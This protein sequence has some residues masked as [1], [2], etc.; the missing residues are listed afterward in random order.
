MKKNIKLKCDDVSYM[1]TTT[2]RMLGIKGSRGSGGDVGYG[3]GS[4]RRVMTCRRNI[5]NSPG[6]SC[7]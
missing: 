4:W 5:H 2:S 3:V 6:R 1:N 7:R